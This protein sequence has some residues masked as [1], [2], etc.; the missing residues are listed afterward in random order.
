M[1]YYRLKIDIDVR[2]SLHF[3]KSLEPLSKLIYTAIMNSPLQKLHLQK[4]GFKHYVFSNL[5]KTSQD[6][7]YPEGKNFFFFRTPKK[8]LAFNVA[9][10][11]IGYEDK[12][13]KVLGVGMK[14]ANIK[15]INSFITINP[16]VM[17]FTKNG[18]RR[19]WT[20]YEDGDI[21]FLMDALHN[22]L[23]K[24]YEDLYDKKLET[25]ENFIELLEIKNQ[26]PLAMKYKNGKIFGNK[27]YIVPK[28]DKA[29]QKLAALALAEGLGEKNT[30]GFGFCR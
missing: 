20:I 26:K 12:I 15:H 3:Q 7:I 10:K 29:S 30:L 11:L 2:T 18:K 17:T 27:F 22:N 9:K 21:S 6:K 13:F 24:K 8:E 19:N 4:G 1:Q 23:V 25:K 5:V 14:E 16:A 28:G